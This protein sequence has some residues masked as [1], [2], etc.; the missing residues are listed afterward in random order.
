MSN[1]NIERTAT[2]KDNRTQGTPKVVGYCRVSTDMQAESGLSLDAQREQI[3]AYAKLRGW[4]VIKILVD[5][6]YSGKNKDRPAL[7]ELLTLVKDSSTIHAVV[8]TKLDRL[9]RSI[10]DT[11]EI[12]DETL[13]SRGVGFVSIHDGINT[14]ETAGKS[15]L[16]FLSVIAQ[17]ERTN[18]SERVKNTIR[19]VK[20]SGYHYGK[21]P[22]GS[23]T[24]QDGRYK[25]LVDDPKEAPWRERMITWYRE[26]MSLAEITRQLNENGIQ[27]KYG[28]DRSWTI[29]KVLDY[30]RTI[31]VH[32]PRNVQSDLI[33]DKAQAHSI[34]YEMR[35][36]GRPYKMIVE[37]L[38]SAGLRP[39]NAAKYGVT[40][41]Q[42]LLRSA[43]FFEKSTPRGLALSLQKQG[44]SLREIGKRLLEAGH[45]P[46]RGGQWWPNT[47][48]MLMLSPEKF[49]PAC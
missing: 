44:L 43:V 2:I 45:V 35:S 42:D 5:P 40:S 29:S 3:L 17:L 15:F 6:G 37:A 19:H 1:H 46:P 27:T 12:V 24:V 36:D 9:T 13:E 11:I 25:K 14:L 10:K 21:I 8:V 48:K 18:T 39:K 49:D 30:L 4:L 41:V 26:G 22:F 34:A 33:F 23:T 16:Y 32:K 38:T 28:Q 20:N 47:I 31:G 7:Q